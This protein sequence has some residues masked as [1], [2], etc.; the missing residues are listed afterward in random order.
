ML[1]NPPVSKPTWKEL[2][3][4]PEPLLLPAAHDALT[5]HLIERAGFKAF[6]VGGF[7]LAGTRFSFPD[8][9][10]IHY[11]ELEEAL[12]QITAASPLPVLVAA[13]DGCG[14]VTTV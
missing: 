13:G 14:A 11:Y 1:P 8:I 7:A 4:G 6:Q 2:V 10:L 3:T 9:D 5:A 12:R